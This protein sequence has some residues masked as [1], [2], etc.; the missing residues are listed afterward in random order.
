[1][2]PISKRK[3]LRFLREKEAC[4]YGYALAKGYLEKHTVEQLIEYYFR[5]IKYRDGM[6]V[7]KLN[8]IRVE[9]ARN[10]GWLTL[11]LSC[12]ASW[13]NWPTGVINA[14]RERLSME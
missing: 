14:I 8:D 3:F 7:Y 9:R 12:G 13:Q 11:R 1:M 5:C 10:L 2:K 4:P 6:H